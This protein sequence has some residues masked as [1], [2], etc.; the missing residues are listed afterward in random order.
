MKSMK[1]ITTVTFNNPDVCVRECF[2]KALLP[3]HL[4]QASNLA[5]KEEKKVFPPEHNRGP[6]PTPAHRTPYN[7]H[8]VLANSSPHTAPSHPPPLSSQPSPPSTTE[9]SLHSRNQT[10]LL[11]WRGGTLCIW[12]PLLLFPLY[13]LPSLQVHPIHPPLPLFCAPY[14]LPTPASG[15]PR[16]ICQRVYP[17]TGERE[18]RGTRGRR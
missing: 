8:Q 7:P 11:R 17:Q 3:Q 16:P 6:P 4:L 1:T 18:G 2:G 14:T 13:W 5:K 9:S 10:S 12:Q 15:C